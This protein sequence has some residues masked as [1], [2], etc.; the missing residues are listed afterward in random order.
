MV[1]TIPAKRKNLEQRKTFKTGAVAR[2]FLMTT[3]MT[4]RPIAYTNPINLKQIQHDLCKGQL[5]TLI[6]N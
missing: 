3:T 5:L 1:Y 2:D 6:D 4:S